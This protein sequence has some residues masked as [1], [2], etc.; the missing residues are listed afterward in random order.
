M[1]YFSR[2]EVSCSLPGVFMNH[3]G[4]G[5]LPDDAVAQVQHA[6]CT[7]KIPSASISLDLTVARG[8]L[9]SINKMKLCL[10]SCLFMGWAIAP[11][12]A[13]S[14][15]RPREAKGSLN[16]P[17]LLCS[18]EIT[19]NVSQCPFETESF[20]PAQYRLEKKMWSARGLGMESWLCPLA[21]TRHFG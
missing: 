11:Q 19:T 6:S 8:Y 14:A 15:P 17:G 1:R 16:D 21:Y 2:H 18:F 10:C 13:G 9:C 7:S 3:R 12:S 4:S 5:Q 20:V